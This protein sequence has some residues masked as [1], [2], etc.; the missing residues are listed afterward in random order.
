MWCV[1]LV[2]LDIGAPQV[3]A[4]IIVENFEEELSAIQTI[5][6]ETI[7]LINMNYQRKL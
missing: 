7:K 2:V 4:Q 3:K 1:I 6:G 5:I